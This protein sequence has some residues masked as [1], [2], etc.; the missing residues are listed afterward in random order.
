MQTQEDVKGLHNC[1]E[2]SQSLECLYQAM[3]TQ[4]KS[5]SLEINF[6]I[7]RPCYSELYFV[8]PS[9]PYS[10]YQGSTA[11]VFKISSLSN[12][13]YLKMLAFYQ[14]NGHLLP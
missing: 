4:D 12:I 1:L 13:Q 2:F 9:A 14:F 10:L 11:T 3:Q 5:F 8:R 6:D 7:T